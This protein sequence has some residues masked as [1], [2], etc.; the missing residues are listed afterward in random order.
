MPL[1]LRYWK[2]L[3]IIASIGFILL[4][5]YLKGRSDYAHH[6]ETKDFQ[7]VKRDIERVERER[8]QT[9]EVRHSIRVNR[10]SIKDDDA[11]DSCI[12]SNDPFT[13]KCI[14]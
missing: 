14:N 13:I 1:I 4:S 7:E 6:I 3:S 9:E 10:Q 2:Q 12:L 8:E 5:F 11:R